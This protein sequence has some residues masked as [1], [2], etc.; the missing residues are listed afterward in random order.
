[1]KIHSKAIHVGDRKKAGP[2]VPVTTPVYTATSFTYD[3]METLDRVLGREEPGFSYARYDSPTAAAVEEVITDLEN[4]AG[5]LTCSSGMAAVYTAVNTALVDRRRNVIAAI[6]LYGATVGMLTNLLEPAGVHVR[7]VDV[8]NLD[9]LKA[10]VAEEKPGA[11][12]IESISNPLLRVAEIDKV[13]EIA[14]EA[15]A[16]LI[17][18]NTFA[19]PLLLR[20]IELGANFVVHS[21]TKYLAGHGDVMGGSVTADA[22]HLDHLRAYGRLVGPLL[23]PFE[24]YLTMRGI[25]TFPLRMERHC[26]NACHVASWLA[27]HPGVEKVNFP[28]DPSHPDAA[29]IRRQ[30]P[31]NLFGAMISFEIKG[32]RKPEVFRFMDALKMVVRGTSLGDVHTMTLYPAISSHRD[33][34]PKQRERIGIRE[35]LVRL[36]IGIEAVEDIIAD[37]EQALA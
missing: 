25:K 22:A 23:G 21:L 18:D 3:A 7:F 30:F 29:A 34:A 12:V 35:N 37:I 27:A 19:T 26:S 8:C 31:P 11:I 28:A 2:F 16:A 17:V 36:S 9:A 13:A 20:P 6:G 5:T 4:G 24:C 15:G 10:A 1:M 32:A 33:I 14:R